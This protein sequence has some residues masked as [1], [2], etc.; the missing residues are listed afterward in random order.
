MEE[1][2]IKILSRIDLPTLHRIA[3]IVILNAIKSEN[4]GED[5][6]ELS[7]ILILKYGKQI[8]NEKIIR[9]AIINSL[10]NDEIRLLGSK[11]KLKNKHKS[12]YSNTIDFFT[13]GYNIEKSK[14]FIDFLELN[15]KYYLSEIIDIRKEKEVINAKYGEEIKILSYLHPYQK[16]VKDEIMYRLYQKNEKSFFVQMPTGAGKTLTALECVVD[17]FRRPNP[18]TEFKIPGKNKYIVWLVDTNELAEQAFQSF[19]KLWK[20]RG[21]R[22]INSFRLFKEFNPNFTIENGGIVFAGFDKFYSIL[23]DSNSE[24]FNSIIH[25]IRNS[26]LLIIDEAHHSLAETYYTCINSFKHTPYIKILGLSA[27]PGSNDKE[28][29]LKLVELYSNDKISIRDENWNPINNTIKY[30]QEEGYLAKLSTKILETGVNTNESNENRV[31]IELASNSERNEKI[32]EQIKLAN[33]QKESTLVFACS[34]DH[35]YA[36]LILCRA[37][38]IHANYITG[39]VDQSERLQIIE[40]FKNREYFILI[41]LEILSTGIDLPNVNKIIITRPIS[42]PNLLSQIL[43]RAL[44]GEKNGGNKENTIINI[45]DNLLNYPSASYLYEYFEGAWEKI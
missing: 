44:R 24:H 40:S 34:L 41:N 26:E 27:T 14:I 11:C 45:K 37:K 17:I 31:L 12:I 9:E 7:K 30:L 16:R 35:V 39:S 18:L 2:L 32:I 20:L 25:L 38:G 1:K 19:Y 10:T 21:D 43:G 4:K 8:F 3:G 42:S 5:E 13:R 6:R 15:E 28:T 23:S 29:T 33:D 36:L 22:I